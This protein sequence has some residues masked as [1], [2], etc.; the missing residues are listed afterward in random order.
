MPRSAPFA[1]ALMLSLTA[2]FAPALV[3]AQ[4]PTDIFLLHVHRGEDGL[5]VDSVRRLTDRDGY[6]NQPYFTP[7]GGTLLFTRIDDAGQADIHAIDLA[8]GRIRPVTRT[9]P[10]SEYS[11]TPMPGG[12]RFSAIRVEADSTQRLWSFAMDGSDPRLLLEDIRP[13]GYHAWLDDDRIALY[14]LGSPATL[15]LA[16]LRSGQARQLASNIG[17]SLHRLPDR[18]AIS[19]VQRAEAPGPGTIRTLDPATGASESLVDPFAENEYHAWLAPGVLLTG[20]DSRLFT[21]RPGQDDGWV[22][23]PDLAG[24]GIHGISRIA[25]SPDRSK[26]AIVATH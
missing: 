15:Q 5:A 22:A 10:E 1:A 11:A 4:D 8:S 20:R 9:A 16:D 13:V 3:E 21:F 12:R 24:S 25:V 2:A 23:G 17:R 6:D 18:E 7:D 19:Y 26:I 14:V